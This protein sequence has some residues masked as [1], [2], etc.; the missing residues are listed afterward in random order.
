M[1]EATVTERSPMYASLVK[2]IA[3]GSIYKNMPQCH[4]N[5]LTFSLSA[6]VDF[7]FRL[8]TFFDLLELALF[9]YKP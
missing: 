3:R 9:A 5:F 2:T 6:A 4:V 7:L 8:T 1:T